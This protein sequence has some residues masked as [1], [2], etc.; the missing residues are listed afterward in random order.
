MWI[1]NAIAQ[2][3]E[4]YWEYKI[5]PLNKVYNQ[6]FQCKISGQLGPWKSTFVSSSEQWIYI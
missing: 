2:N 1:L 4:I 5:D 3:Y 6:D